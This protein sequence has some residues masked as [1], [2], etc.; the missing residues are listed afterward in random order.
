[1]LAHG[2]DATSRR[3]IDLA[4]VQPGLDK[5]SNVLRTFAR[6]AEG[7]GKLLGRRLGQFVPV[8]Q[9]DKFD[10]LP[11]WTRLQLD[12]HWEKLAKEHENSKDLIQLA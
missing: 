5:F 12:E 7:I 1:M 11:E 8:A 3:K 2:A 10:R 6:V 4:A 9:F